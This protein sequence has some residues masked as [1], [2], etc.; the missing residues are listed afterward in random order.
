MQQKLSEVQKDVYEGLAAEDLEED[1]GVL[2]HDHW[3]SS[4]VA[5]LPDESGL[6]VV[7]KLSEV[8]SD[9]GYVCLI[10]EPP[11][12]KQLAVLQVNKQSFVDYKNNEFSLSLAA[13]LH[14]NSIQANR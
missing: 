10:I 3:N 5:K 1:N 2:E 14:Y 7:A 4:L 11:G 13:G 8:A 9:H 6:N 12:G